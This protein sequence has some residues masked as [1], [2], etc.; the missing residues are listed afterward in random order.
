[1]VVEFLRFPPPVAEAVMDAL[2]QS[3]EKIESADRP[4]G[5]REFL[6]QGAD[7]IDRIGLMAFDMFSKIP[8]LADAIVDG[9]GPSGVFEI[10]TRMS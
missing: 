1:M 9:Q 8:L 4:A 7:L 3:C 2:R 5:G 10:A 6:A